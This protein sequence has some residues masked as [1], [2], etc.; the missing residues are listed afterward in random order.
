MQKLKSALS[1]KEPFVGLA[2]KIAT[3]PFVGRLCFVRAYSGVL[4]SGS[5]IQ[6]TRSGQ[7]N[8]FH[9]YS[10]C[11]PTSRTRS[12]DYLLGDIGAVVGF[13]RH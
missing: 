9:V 7:K 5:Y 1:E 11:T 2:F 12:I 10:R 8:G 13:Q 4:E 6:N 3:D